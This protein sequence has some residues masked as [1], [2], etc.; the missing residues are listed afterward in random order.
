MFLFIYLLYDKTAR[1]CNTF[2]W[3]VHIS[4][5]CQGYCLFYCIVIGTTA[6]MRIVIVDRIIVMNCYHHCYCS[7]TGTFST[8]LLRLMMIVRTFGM[9][10]C[11]YSYL[12]W[13]IFFM[14]YICFT[15][16]III[17]LAIVI[18]VCTSLYPLL[19]SHTH[20]QTSKHT[21]KRPQPRGNTTALNQVTETHH[22]HP[23]A[24]GALS[25]PDFAEGRRE[26]F[27]LWSGRGHFSPPPRPPKSEQTGRN[28]F[29]RGSKDDGRLV[30]TL[31]ADCG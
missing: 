20:K 8:L 26:L 9:F 28:E 10:G 30:F 11:R 19:L 31:G 2:I 5:F 14:I 22:H 7:F 24:D 27:G 16:C 18:I 21:D 23:S 25:G 4:F 13:F 15:Y 6:V 1:E 17:R 12:V 3:N 29:A